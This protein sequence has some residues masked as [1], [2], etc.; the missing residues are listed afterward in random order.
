[1]GIMAIFLTK[2]GGIKP[3]TVQFWI[4]YGSVLFPCG[5]RDEGFHKTSTDGDI[6]RSPTSGCLW[7]REGASAA[8]SSLALKYC[9]RARG[10]G[11]GDSLEPGLT[12]AHAAKRP[13]F[14]KMLVSALVSTLMTWPPTRRLPGSWRAHLGSV[15]RE[16]SGPRWLPG[17]RELTGVGVDLEEGRSL[18]SNTWRSRRH[19]GNSP[20]VLNSLHHAGLY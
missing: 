18:N 11:P 12:P 19:P 2:D 3:G 13:A 16:G 8:M 9:Y 1:M 4:A 17:G 14:G 10:H 15:G 20:H 7:L 5:S 6:P